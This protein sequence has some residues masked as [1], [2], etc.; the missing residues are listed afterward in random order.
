MTRS[1]A[2]GRAATLL[3][4]TRGFG[5]VHLARLAERT[6][7]AELVAVADPAGAPAEGFGADAPAFASLDEALAAGI[8]PEVVIVATPTPTHASLAIRAL[9]IGADVYL[10]KPPVASMADFDRLLEAERRSGRSVQVGFQSLGS[11]ALDAIAAEGDV[12]SVAA[13]GTWLRSRGYWNRSAWAGRRT[14]DGRP[15]VDGVV[16]NPLAHAVATALHIAGARSADDVAD[17]ELE[18]HRAAD[19]EADDT[20]S[21]RVTLASGI[22]IGIALTLCSPE[23]R[24][25]I[26]QVRTTGRDLDFSY[27]LDELRESGASPDG[28]TDDVRRFGRTDLFDDLLEHRRTGAPLRSPLVQAGAFMRVLEAVRLA[29]DPAPIPAVAIQWR[30]EGDEAHPVVADVD[31]WVRRAAEQAALFSELHVPWAKPAAE[32]SAVPIGAPDDLDRTHAFALRDPGVSVVATSSPRP[33]LHPIRTPGGVVVSDAHPIDHDWHLGLSFTVQHAAGVNFWG[34]RTWVRDQGY[35]WL[36]DHGRIETVDLVVRPDGYDASSAW[37]DPHGRVLLEQRTALRLDSAGEGGANEG[38]ANEAGSGDGRAGGVRAF[39]L[40]VE[41]RTAG[42][43]P[44]TLGSP[45][46]G[47]RADAG[48]GGLAWR[49]PFGE[50]IDVRTPDASGEADCHGRPARWLAYTARFDGGVA[51]VALA[52]ADAATAADPWFVRVE[53]Y[54]GIGSAI[55]WDRETIVGPEPLVRRWRGLVADGDP[56]DAVIERLLAP[57]VRGAA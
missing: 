35:R 22:R 36:A 44:I 3:V 41:L 43:E 52:G 10:E 17:V 6:E 5:A 57:A 54:P 13:Y 46:S 50:D 15:V 49:L 38:G 30:G 29:P 7:Q 55:A 20:S 48:Y 53:S 51:T 47:G 28:E 19:I 32:T 12:R 14:I 37:L 11:A 34:G 9:E 23:Q 16:T 4:G 2:E 18:L 39:E 26:V 56:G 42:P 25:P 45:G 21:V 8:R 40:A 1:A 31:R 27:T 24:P 33:F